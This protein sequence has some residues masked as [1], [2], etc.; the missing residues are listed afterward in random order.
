MGTSQS[1]DRTEEEDLWSFSRQNLDTREKARKVSVPKIWR[2]PYGEFKKELPSETAQERAT[3]SF[4]ILSNR[5]PNERLNKALRA[6]KDNRKDTFSGG[7]EC[8]PTKVICSDALYSLAGAMRF[9]RLSQSGETAH[10]EVAALKLKLTAVDLSHCSEIL[11]RYEELGYTANPFSKQS[12]VPFSHVR[13][14]LPLALGGG[15]TRKSLTTT[16][17]GADD[18]G[19]E[20]KMFQA[21]EILISRSPDNTVNV[22]LDNGEFLP[23]IP[24]QSI[25]LADD[26]EKNG[27]YTPQFYRTPKTG[28]KG[29]DDDDAI[30]ADS[31]IEVGTRIIMGRRKDHG[32]F[33]PSASARA[34]LTKLVSDVK[35][36]IPPGTVIAK[37]MIQVKN[38]F[39]T[40]IATVREIID[41]IASATTPKIHQR[42]IVRLND[43]ESTSEESPFW[44]DQQKR[45]FVF[46]IWIR[47]ESS[48]MSQFNDDYDR[49]AEELHK[50][51]DAA[52]DFHFNKD[53]LASSAGKDMGVCVFP[54]KGI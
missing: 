5:E 21:A 2:A 52:F 53:L 10:P 50:Q 27:W 1:V 19:A 18:K 22:M 12:L 43:A 16:G 15:S 41:V 20:L 38:V 6:I 51:L 48:F 17:Y 30:V 42:N 35:V 34:R 26:E 8:D 33:A 25:V 13:A 45:C 37:C 46:L 40:A 24:L 28:N 44:H 47:D 4:A 11:Y 29:E 31:K 32:I 23:A 7:K 49:K 39:G 3:S 9:A 14:L 54:P 36:E